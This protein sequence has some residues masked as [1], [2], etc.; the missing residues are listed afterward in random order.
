MKPVATLL[1]GVL[2]A[3]VA[4]A[5]DVYVTTDAQGRRIYTDT[6]QTLPAQKL[7]IRSQTTDPAT[8]TNGNS[9]ALARGGKPDNVDSKN[10]VVQVAQNTAEDRARRC[11][12]ARQQYQMLMTSW[13]VYTTGPDDSRTYLTSEQIDQ[14]R[15]NAKQAMDQFC[16]DE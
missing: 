9:S 6:P 3:G 15:A 10:P 16:T 5:G 4:G 8:A 11:T 2:L 12:D 7:N 1:A 13:Q 14:A